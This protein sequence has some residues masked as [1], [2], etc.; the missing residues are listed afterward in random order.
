MG[1]LLF[2]CFFSLF[3]VL[4]E[5][6]SCLGAKFTQIGGRKKNY[7]FVDGEMKIFGVSIFELDRFG[8]ENL[9]KNA[10]KIFEPYR[11]KI[12]IYKIKGNAFL[13]VCPFAT[14]VCFFLPCVK[15][16]FFS[17]KSKNFRLNYPQP[18]KNEVFFSK[19]FQSFGKKY[20]ICWV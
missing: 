16:I 13:C 11:E 15:N 3:V 5:K 9:K 20:I 18:E 12:G 7:F 4:I 6:K 14:W 19:T 2:F 1:D 17:P 8:K 10:W